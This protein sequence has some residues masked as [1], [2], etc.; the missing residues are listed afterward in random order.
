MK[1]LLSSIIVVMFALSIVSCGN[2]TK[3][4]NSSNIPKHEQASPAT[5]EKT[6]ILK[7]KDLKGAQLTAFDEQGRKLTFQIKDVELDPKDAQKE[8]Y[9]YTVFYQDTA[10]S[11]WKN[12]CEPDAENVAKA[13][14]LSGS[15]DD[16]GAHIDSKELFTFACTNGALAK[17]DRLGYKPWKKVEGK[18][19]RNYHQACTRMVR[20]DYCG[21]GNSHTRDGTQIDVYDVLGIQKPTPN[22][23]MVFEAAWG[24]DGATCI[25]RPRWFESLSDIRKECPEKL[26]SRI[27]VGGSCSTAEKA[28]QKWSDSLLFNDSLQRKPL[29]RGM[30]KM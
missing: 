27:N 24:P 4:Q 23:N 6:T 2:L 1:K 8:T 7:G 20:A 19:L 3:E 10:D 9:L 16:K 11:Q 29:N 18:S 12:L 17:C 21:N 25:N 14:S 28:R 5:G 13:I 26:K 15:W 22:D 30:T